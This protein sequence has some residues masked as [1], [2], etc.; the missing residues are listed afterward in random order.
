[1]SCPSCDA[2]MHNFGCLVSGRPAFWCPRCGTLKTC[3]GH[4][5]A[6]DLPRR[7]RTF[8]LLLGRSP[9][10]LAEWTRLGVAEAVAAPNHFTDAGAFI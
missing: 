10:L 7:C 5:A 9:V 8:G 1:M 4:V 3:E 2:T 6:P